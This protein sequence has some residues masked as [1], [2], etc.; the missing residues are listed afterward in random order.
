MSVEIKKI[1]VSDWEKYKKLR[2]E[3]L[4]KEPQSFAGSFEDS[5]K[6]EDRV[7]KDNLQQS[8]DENT[9]FF[10]FACDGDKLVG[11]IGAFWSDKE[12]I[13]HIANIGYVYVKPEYRDKGIGS[14]L[15]KEVLIKLKE[16]KFIKK[17]KLSVVT[18]Q[19][20]ALGL[21][22]K[23]G[24]KIVEKYEKELKVGKGYFDE[25]LLEKLI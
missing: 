24:F 25:Y 20:T 12:K 13:K 11:M 7:W 4:E 18:Q 1:S 23:H 9:K 15:M 3:A 17:I 19:K 21:Y 14:L 2:L 16:K 22:E 10:L 6:F 5:L 8:E